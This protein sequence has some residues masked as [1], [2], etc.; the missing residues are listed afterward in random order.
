MACWWACC[1]GSAAWPPT[2]RSSPCAPRAWA[3]AT[4]C[5]SPPSWPLPARCLAWATRCIWRRAPIRPS[6]RWNRRWKPRRPPTRFS[7][8]SS[9]RTFKN[10]VLYVQDVRSGAGAA[11]WRQVFM[12]DVT[13]P[14]NPQDHHRRLRHRGQRQLQELL[15]RLRDGS[16]HETVAGQPQQYN[17]STF[18]TTDMPLALSQQS[19]V[20]LGRMD[21]AIYALPMSALLERTARSRRQALPDRVAQPL[22]L[23]RR[24]PGADAGGR[25]AGRGFAPRR[26]ELRCR[27]YHSAGL[28]LLL[29]LLHR[30]RTGPPEQAS[31]VLRG[32]V[33]QPALRRAGIFLLWQMA[34]GGRI[35][36]AIAA[37]PRVLPNPRPPAKPNG[38][39]SPASR[40]G[41]SRVRSAQRPRGVFPRILDEYIVREF[42]NMFCWCWPALCCSCWSSPSSIWWATSCATTF[43]SPRSATIWST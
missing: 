18:A 17:I 43:R 10:F 36:N 29:P 24:L 14:A 4:L 2:A 6:S 38:F 9:T 26:Q 34:S 25:S 21:T 27:L 22:R 16:R 40:A 37:G 1:W 12:A 15:M 3:S 28:R 7:L 30:H 11:N 20:H 41:C 33:G 5:A 13:D 39:R 35:L 23:S 19:D 32:V 31:R 42:L 8:A